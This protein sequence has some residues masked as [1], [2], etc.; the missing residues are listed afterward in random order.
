[1]IITMSLGRKKGATIP[2]EYYDTLSAFIINTLESKTEVELNELIDLAKEEHGH[3]IKGEI[4]WFLLVVK[5]DLE[6]RKVIKVERA[7]GAS[8]Q[9]YL[10]L[11]SRRRM[12]I[13]NRML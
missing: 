10:T 7:I 12:S 6:A 1:M 2:K 8:R 11:N 3:L 9:Q 13:T 5:N 4:S